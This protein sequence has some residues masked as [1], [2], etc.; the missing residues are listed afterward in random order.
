MA[1]IFVSRPGAVIAPKAVLTTDRRSQ[2]GATGRG[3]PK[4]GVS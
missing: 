1:S 4:V 2:K 3:H